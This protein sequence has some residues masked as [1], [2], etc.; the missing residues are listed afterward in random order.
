MA[1]TY[2]HQDKPL[3]LGHAVNAARDFIGGDNFL[4]Y[5]GDNLLEFGVKGL[6][7]E[8]AKRQPS[9]LLSVKEVADPRAYGVAVLEGNRV[10]SLVEKPEVPPSSWAIVGAYAFQPQILE[11][12]AATPPSARGEY[13]I[14]DAIQRLIAEGKE[15]LACPV[16][17]FW[18][19]AGRPA[20]LELPTA[21]PRPEPGEL[22]AAGLHDWAVRLAGRGQ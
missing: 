8:F 14:T 1:V 17:G 13:E 21:G 2:L 16:E 22:R 15:V 5:L 9:A 6:V 4:L 7:A 3:G 18:E 10:L 11:A 19:D 12:I 20:G